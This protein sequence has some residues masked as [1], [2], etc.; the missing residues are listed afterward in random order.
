MRLIGDF[1]IREIL[2]EIVALPTGESMGK[3]SG[4]ISLNPVGRFLMEALATDQTEESLVEAVL[5]EYNADRETVEQDVRE[6]LE[7]LRKNSLI[8]EP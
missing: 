1:R 3:F 7:V 8:I 5:A 4:I 6:F 2:D